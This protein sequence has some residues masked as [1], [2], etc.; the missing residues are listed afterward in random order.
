MNELIRDHLSFPDWSRG[1]AYGGLLSQSPTQ[2]EYTLWKSPSLMN[3]SGKH[4][5]EAWN[6]FRRELGPEEKRAV[7]VILHDDLERQ[8]GK[9]RLRLKGSAQGHNGLKSIIQKLG[10]EVC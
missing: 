7:L 5:K 4:V 2:P 1:G 9:V 10:T 8:L 6:A 3:V